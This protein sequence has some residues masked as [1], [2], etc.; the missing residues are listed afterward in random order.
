MHAVD[1][2]EEGEAGTPN[3]AAGNTT[4]LTGGPVAEHLCE[5]CM[6][7]PRSQQHVPS[8]YVS[9]IERTRIFLVA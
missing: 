5:I 8:F 9:A 4:V 6:V 1:D 2:A 7:H 3:T